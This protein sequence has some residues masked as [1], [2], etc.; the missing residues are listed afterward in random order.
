MARVARAAAAIVCVASLCWGAGTLVHRRMRRVYEW[1]IALPAARALEE[2]AEACQSLSLNTATLEE[3][4]ALPRIGSVLAERIVAYR[5]AMDG[6][7]DDAELMRIQGIGETTYGLLEPL[8]CV[9]TPFP[10]LP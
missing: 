9:C 6:Y 3:L 5:E 8:V 10:A 7:V 4:E 1:R 2:P